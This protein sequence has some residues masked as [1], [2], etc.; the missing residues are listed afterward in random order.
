[1][2]LKILNC[3]S[4]QIFHQGIKGGTL[5][6]EWVPKIKSS[7]DITKRVI[8][9][10]EWNSEMSSLG[11]PWTILGITKSFTSNLREGYDY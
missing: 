11:E 5:M 7:W 2:N 3:K 4:N 9:G 6:V 1:M 10:E 8:M